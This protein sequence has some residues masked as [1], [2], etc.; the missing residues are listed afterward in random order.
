MR[1]AIL[2]LITA[3]LLTIGMALPVAAT[4]LVQVTMNCDDG[5]STTVVVD[6]DTL[7]DLIASVQAML[8]Y[9]AGLT[10]ALIQVPLLSPVAGVAIAASSDMFVVGGGR[11]LVH[12][13]AGTAPTV[14]SSGSFFVNIA[15]NGQKKSDGSFVGT[16]NETI[17][18]QSCGDVA[19]GASHFTSKLGPDG[20]CVSFTTVT[21]DSGTF[22]QAY[23]T[24]LVTEV[25]GPVTF[26][27]AGG[28]ELTTNPLTYVRFGFQDNGHP[29]VATDWLN[30]IPRTGAFGPSTTSECNLGDP[31]PEPE[32]ANGN[33]TVHQ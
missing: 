26:R 23:V 28:P 33:I 1:R 11:W 4:G 7:N 24:S 15:V 9:P 3:A 2:A 14:D 17:P 16:L 29:S 22:G 6:T 27:T 12:C 18:E 19:V 30:G 25:T 32:L 5:T 13:L 20:T 31:T 21:I 10:C 8:D